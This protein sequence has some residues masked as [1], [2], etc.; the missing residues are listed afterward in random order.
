[1]QEVRIIEAGVGHSFVLRNL[2]EETFYD[3]FAR[4]NEPENLREYMDSAFSIS[5][6]E[7]ELKEHGSIYFIAYLDQTPVGYARLRIPKESPKDLRSQKSIELQRIYARRLYIGK[8]IGRGLLQTCIDKSKQQ[9]YD[10]M[11]LGVWERNERAI[12]FYER[13]GFVK[14]GAHTFH[15]GKDA[16]KD[17]LMK[18]ALK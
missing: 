13:W 7:S 12:T 15:L 11:W 10:T 4:D 6:I 5:Q 17:I 14:F 3:S 1:M 18:L 2:A 16:Q 9:G 8:G